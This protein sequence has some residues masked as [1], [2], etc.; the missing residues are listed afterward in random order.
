MAELKSDLDQV[1]RRRTLFADRDLRRVGGGVE[2]IF[3]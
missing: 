3:G 2:K 1:E